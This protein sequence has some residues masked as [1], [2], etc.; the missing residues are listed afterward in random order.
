M[1][2]SCKVLIEADDGLVLDTIDQLLAKVAEKISRTRNG[3]DWE[4]WILGRPVDIRVAT[5]PP[6]VELSA[7]CNQPE[8]YIVL[9][10]LSQQ[11]ANV[12]GGIPSEPEK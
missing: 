5:S 9:R 6:A 11:I 7:G 3:R 12:L 8:D 4:V 2:P 10:E 1:G